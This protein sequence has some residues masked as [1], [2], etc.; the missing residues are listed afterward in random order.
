METD[1]L[2]FIDGPSESRKTVVSLVVSKSQGIVLGQ[3]RWFG[4]WRQYCFYPNSDT[5]WNKGCLDAIN[6]KIE[7]LQQFWKDDQKKRRQT[8]AGG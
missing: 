1:Y 5:I 3:I 4:R 2:K 6:A 8:K 7:Q